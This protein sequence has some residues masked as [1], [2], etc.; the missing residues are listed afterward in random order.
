MRTDKN[1]QKSDKNN[2]LERRNINLHK[3]GINNPLERRNI[4]IHKSDINN[5]LMPLLSPLIYAGFM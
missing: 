2:P 1:L 4:N 3:L 5:L